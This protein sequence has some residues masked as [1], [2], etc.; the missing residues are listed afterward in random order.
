MQ[1]DQYGVYSIFLPDHN[2]QP[3]I[4]HATKLKISI[5]T[6]EGHREDRIPAWSKVVWVIQNDLSKPSPNFL[7]ATTSISDVRWSVLESGAT[8]PL[9][10]STSKTR[11]RFEDLRSSYWNVIE[12][13]KNLNLHRI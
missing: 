12:R 11:F 3:A 7:T 8:L 2:G 10:I 9:E 5:I 6:P 1:R 4:K 13:S